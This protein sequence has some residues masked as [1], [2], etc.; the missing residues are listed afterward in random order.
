MTA[1]REIDFCIDQVFSES[2]RIAAAELAIRENSE[3][4]PRIKRPSGI[5]ILPA[6]QIWLAQMTGRKWE[7]GRE[8]RVR[9][10]DGEARMRDRVKYYSSRWMEHANLPLVFCDDPRAEIKISFKIQAMDGGPSARSKIG[11][12]ALAVKNPD[13][14]TMVLSVLKPDSSEEYFCRKATHE[15]GHALGFIHEHQNPI[16]GIPWDREKAIRFYMQSSGWTEEEV[17]HNVFRTYGRDLTQFSEFDPK[18][19][20]IYPI[21]RE[22]TLGGFEVRLNTE[23]SETDKAFAAAVYPKQVKDSVH[24]E[25]GGHPVEAEIGKHYEVDVFDFRVEMPGNHLIQTGGNTD[26]EMVLTG[27]NS[28]TANLGYDND[29]G[30]AGNARIQI[31]LEAG[32]YFVHIRHFKPMGSG[33]YNLSVRKSDTG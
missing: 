2:E 7:T 9:F 33:K 30:G 18:S 16:G 5:G 8:L 22:I 19:I 25:I 24:L 10:L 32:E 3:N 17:I 26:L 21:P 15:F 20:M 14:P 4:V 11:T 13:E 12:D 1:T 28:K 27:P 6:E 31:R 29:S 23:L